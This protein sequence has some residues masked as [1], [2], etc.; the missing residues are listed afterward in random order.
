MK[1]SSS[2]DNINLLTSQ[3]GNKK[4]ES[5][6]SFLNNTSSVEIISLNDT[7][8]K[9]DGL[10]NTE[11]SNMHLN[12]AMN[13]A[14]KAKTISYQRPE[15]KTFFKVVEP[16]Q[17]NYKAQE[18]LMRANETAA[19]RR[20][21]DRT[22]AAK[23]NDNES[24][25][26]TN[27]DE[28][29]VDNADSLEMDSLKLQRQEDKSTKVNFYAGDQC[30]AVE[31]EN[32]P[33]YERKMEDI[34]KDFVS[35]TSTKEFLVNQLITQKKTYFTPYSNKERAEKHLSEFDNDSEEVREVRETRHAEPLHEKGSLK[36]NDARIKSILKRSTSDS[37][38]TNLNKANNLTFG[39]KAEKIVPK[40]SIE[41]AN[42]R[43]HLK[44]ND[45]STLS[46]KKKSVRFAKIEP[47]VEA[48]GPSSDEVRATSKDEDSNEKSKKFSVKEN[49]NKKFNI[50]F[51]F[52]FFFVLIVY[53][54]SSAL[55]SCLDKQQAL[56][57]AKLLK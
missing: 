32:D 44:T 19:N 26:S 12:L 54:K 33:E 30:D 5:Q 22:T 2:F 3:F 24:F 51:L 9:K 7:N 4:K 27:L 39:I 57:N 38:V 15:Q 16:S 36:A 20:N 52:K 25:T 50:W 34:T 11:F 29:D 42:S 35:K 41:L 45:D 55:K 40:D 56:L 14:N 10:S 48:N 31:A 43:M 23:L 18:D 46:L 53:E 13:H 49:A 28:F 21:G 1:K 47:V 17:Y 8:S 6:D 37:V